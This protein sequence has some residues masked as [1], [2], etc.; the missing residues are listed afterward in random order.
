MTSWRVPPYMPRITVKIKTKRVYGK[1]PSQCL[2]AFMYRFLEK[3]SVGEPKPKHT[4]TGD[5]PPIFEID[6]RHIDLKVSQGLRRKMAIVR[7]L[8]CPSSPL[9]QFLHPTIHPRTV[10]PPKRG[11]EGGS[12]G[13]EHTGSGRVVVFDGN[14]VVH[15]QSGHFSKRLA[16]IP[17]GPIISTHPGRWLR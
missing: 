13:L 14:H 5:I 17:S 16:D 1:A 10:P 3:P 11:R 15:G 2:Y 4:H 6:R 8:D 9:H 7:P 12:V